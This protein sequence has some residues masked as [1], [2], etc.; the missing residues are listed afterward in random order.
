MLFGDRLAHLGGSRPGKPRRAHDGH[1]DLAPF[2]VVDSDDDAFARPAAR[3]SLFDDGGHDRHAARGDRVV[4]PPEHGQAAGFQ[5]ADVAR[6]ER[7]GEIGASH[8]SERHRRAR[9][10]DAAVFDG[11]AGVPD[12]AS[13]VHAAAAGFRHSIRG[14]DLQARGPGGLQ[15]PGAC[16]GP[17][18]ED[19]V[20]AP[21]GSRGRT[22][23]K[24]PELRGNERCV[25]GR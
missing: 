7:P 11:D 17:S 25:K 2:V 6:A 21:G 9:Q 12:G 4:G 13:V 10:N 20:E 19:G 8:V 1:S 24:A 16:G 5:A 3:E 14:D 22:G 18:H 15:K 23:E